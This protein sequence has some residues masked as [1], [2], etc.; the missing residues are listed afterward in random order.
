VKKNLNQIIKNKPHLAEPFRFYNNTLTFRETVT[1]PSPSGPLPQKAYPPEMLRDIFQS[2]SASLELPEATLAPIKRAM[3]LGEIDFTRLPLGEVPAFSL[4]YPEDDLR[5]LLYLLSKPYFLALRQYTGLNGCSWEEGKCPAC[6]GQPVL[7][8]MAEDGRR[9]V[10]C[11][12]CETT[13]TVA[14]SGCPL[15]GGR[16]SARQKVLVFEKEEEFK[17]ATCD[18]CRSYIKT[19]DA[20]VVAKLSPE[21]ADLMSLPLDII[22]Q[23]QG[24]ARRAPNAVGMQKMTSHG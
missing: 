21:I 8:W 3:E 1:I 15:C 10:A 12:F 4:P 2:F 23:E 5:M 20:G 13:G 16:D 19:V 7:T 22:V 24:Y 14:R 9:H 18:L 17:I 6:N 11:S